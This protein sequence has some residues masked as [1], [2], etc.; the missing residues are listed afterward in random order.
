MPDPVEENRPS[1][2]LVRQLKQKFDRMAEHT[3]QSDSTKNHSQ[4]QMAFP[5][6]ARVGHAEDDGAYPL[7]PVCCL[8][9]S[10]CLFIPL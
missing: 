5:K 4:S 6:T 1:S 9:F 8:T 10:F 3:S 2:P 7:F